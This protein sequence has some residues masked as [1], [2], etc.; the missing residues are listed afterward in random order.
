MVETCSKRDDT[1]PTP[2]D[3]SALI[4][5]DETES[6]PRFLILSANATMEATGEK[7]VVFREAIPATPE[8][9]TEAAKPAE[10]RKPRGYQVKGKLALWIVPASQ[11]SQDAQI[12]LSQPN[13]G[14]GGDT[15]L[16]GGYEH[17]KGGRYR[18]MGEAVLVGAPQIVE[19]DPS[20]VDPVGSTPD[21]GIPTVEKEPRYVAYRKENTNE[22]WLRPLA[23]F[24]QQVNGR[25]GS[26]VPR[27][28]RTPSAS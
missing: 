17:Y 22:V 12:D 8:D 6:A 23:D 16:I 20:F 19:P 13:A 14:P 28:R 2:A 4:P 5:A 3:P 27:F 9:P 10:D 24:Q 1:P 11:F 26:V 18:V 15:V 7:Y 25:N 21:A